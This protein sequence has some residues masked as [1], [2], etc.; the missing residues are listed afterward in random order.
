M[1]NCWETISTQNTWAVGYVGDM[2][3]VVVTRTSHEPV[4]HTAIIW[5]FGVT[6][7]SGNCN[8]ISN[9]NVRCDFNPFGDHFTPAKWVSTFNLKRELTLEDDEAVI[10]VVAIH[11]GEIK[12]L[13]VTIAVKG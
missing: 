10:Y 13:N 1:E 11:M 7:W 5:Q 3:R 12:K 8:N 9:E 4:R 2:Y 6:N